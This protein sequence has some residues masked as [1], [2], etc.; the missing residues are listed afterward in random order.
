MAVARPQL[1]DGLSAEDMIDLSKQIAVLKLETCHIGAGSYSGSD[2]STKFA[3]TTLLAGE[4][5]TNLIPLGLLA[6]KPVKLD[7]KTESAKTLHHKLETKRTTTVEITINGISKAKKEFLE[8][9]SESGEV[10]TIVGV[11]K[12]NS[13]ALIVNGQTWSVAWSG[14]AFGLYTMVLSAEFSGT[15]DDTVIPLTGIEDPA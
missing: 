1:P 14:E 3:D 12:D 8:G 5:S 15:T 6:E 2:I 10:M 4:L 11:S 9:I 7:S 13:Q